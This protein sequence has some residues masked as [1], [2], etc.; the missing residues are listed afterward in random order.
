MILS[1]VQI[2]SCFY[3]ISGL[4]FGFFP[5]VVLIISWFSPKEKSV[6]SS[7]CIFVRFQQNNAGLS[8]FLSP[9]NAI[10]IVKR[11]KKAGRIAPLPGWFVLLTYAV[12]GW[13]MPSFFDYNQC[14]LTPKVWE[15]RTEGVDR[16]APSSPPQRRFPLPRQNSSMEMLFT[17]T[18]TPQ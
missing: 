11:N 6:F 9:R 13:P 1:S 5:D 15:C 12:F 2:L 4:P 18:D 17:R 3:P 16:K 10:C 14:N 8:G 7:F